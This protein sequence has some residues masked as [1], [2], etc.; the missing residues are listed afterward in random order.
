MIRQAQVAGQFYPAISSTLRKQLEKLVDKKEKKEAALGVVSPHAGYVFSGKI[1]G[2]LF[3]RVKLTETVIILGPN[4]TG[5]GAA[6]SLMTAGKW[7]MPLGPVEIDAVLAKKILQESQYLK[8]DLQAQLYEHSIEVQLPFL[9]Y[10][11]PEVKIVP[12]IISAADFQVYAE[13]GRAIAKTLKKEKRHCL[14]VASSDMSHYVPQATAETNDHLAIEAILDLDGEKLLEQ[15]NKFNIS[16][17]GFGPVVIMLCAAK[18]QGAKGAKLVKYQTSGEV[19]GDY[20]SVVGYAG[21][22]VQ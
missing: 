1:A 11:L 16:M 10:F 12:I 21:I 5:L 8:D 2:D 3:S 6:F 22:I 15:I 19:S 7:Q 13:I 17:C 14:I 9:Q 18:A 4:H 20:S